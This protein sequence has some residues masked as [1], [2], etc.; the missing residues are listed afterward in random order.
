MILR[1]IIS[2]PKCNADELGSALEKW[3]QT[4]A[5]YERRRDETGLQMRIPEDI[6]MAALE[7]LVPAHLENHIV[8]NKH[9]LTTF[10]DCLAEV[11]SI[12]EARTGMKIKEPSIK[13][14]KQEV[15]KG[16]DLEPIFEESA[17]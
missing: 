5:K 12:V 8:L 14:L 17:V 2:P 13:E 7:M 4:I 3:I 6:K 16:M 15:V 11:T 9:R 1:T 10:Q